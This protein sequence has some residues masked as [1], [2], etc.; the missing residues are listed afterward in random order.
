MSLDRTKKPT[1]MTGLEFVPPVIEEIKFKN[2]LRIFYLYKDK[3]PLIRLNLMIDAGSKYDPIDKKGLAYLTSL[4]L[5]EGADGLNALELSD[6]FDLL[7]SNFNVSTDNDSINLSLQ[8]LTE[9]FERSFELF[10]KVLLY[11]EFKEDDFNREK[12]KLITQIIQ[13]KD[14]PDYLADQ[15]F[16]KII[17]GTSSPYSFPVIGY[18]DSVNSINLNDII[19]HYHNF[20]TASNSFLVI[21]GNTP[22]EQL[23]SLLE[24]Y[25]P[26]WEN[27]STNKYLSFNS[28]SQKNK[29]FMHHKAEAVQTEIRVGQVTQKRDSKDYFQKLLLNAVLGGQFTSRINLNLRERNGY[30][31][32]A[33]SRFQYF[34]ETGFFQV[35]TSVGAE[36]TGN[37]LKEILF[38]IDNIKKGITD[39]ELEF[40]KSS[41]TKKFPMNF[42]TYR[43]IV[44]NVSGKILYDLPDDYFET[45]I[46][47]ISNVT[48]NEVEDIAKTS[49]NNNELV[50]VLVGDKNLIKDKINNLGFDSSEVDINGEIIN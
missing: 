22:R 7:G 5:D 37:A 33:T 47:K 50:I 30:T 41:I 26:G 2:G 42:E 13:S 14:E 15:I 16:D 38:E 8:C 19:N 43:Q 34:K 1:S 9:N 46:D 40:A 36:N 18:E 24:K 49:I 39:Q 23:I 45:Y 31:Y 28:S 27:K 25:L 10:S 17:F 32:G 29:F 11:P 48:K 12:K 44:S 21:V 4:V 35:A 20:F 3:L 6:E